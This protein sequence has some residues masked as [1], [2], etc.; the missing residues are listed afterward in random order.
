MEN[1]Y[2]YIA[3]QILVNTISNSACD[4]MALVMHINGNSNPTK[5]RKGGSRQEQHMHLLRLTS[6]SPMFATI[7]FYRNGATNTVPN[8]QVPWHAW[9]LSLAS[10][11]AHTQQKKK[12]TLGPSVTVVRLGIDPAEKMSASATWRLAWRHCLAERRPRCGSSW[13]CTECIFCVVLT[14]FST[15]LHHIPPVLYLCM[16]A[17]AAADALIDGKACYPN[18]H[19]PYHALLLS[20]M[21]TETTFGGLRRQY[22]QTRAWTPRLHVTQTPV[23]NPD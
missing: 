2:V 18:V 8:P 6:T 11:S 19:V 3:D 23:V 20:T 17:A 5:A 10:S 1:K 16:Q 21:T 22:K 7:R 13:Q 14:T 9:S 4:V 12:K 15:A